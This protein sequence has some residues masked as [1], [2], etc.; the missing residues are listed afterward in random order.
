VGAQHRREHPLEL[1]F[2]THHLASR[3]GAQHG[4]DQHT[5]E[6]GTAQLGQTTTR[7]PMSRAR[8][9]NVTAGSFCSLAPLRGHAVCSRAD[10]SIVD[11][12]ITRVTHPARTEDRAM[13]ATELLT[14][15]HKKVKAAFKRLEGGRGDARAILEELATDLAAH[16][17]IEHELFYPRVRSLDERMVQESFEEHALAELALKRLLSTDPEEPGFRAKVTAVKELVEHHADEEEEDLFPKVDEALDE[18]EHRELGKTMK[19]RFGEA[20]AEG[21]GQLFPRGMAKT[22]ADGARAKPVRSRARKA[23]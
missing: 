23:A 12:D 13:K 15:Q 19:A 5:L 22:L 3:T 9:T 17:V 2:E 1:L 8:G 18:A 10:A 7:R 4:L 21:Y 11:R 16:M 14:Q 6:P 20:Q